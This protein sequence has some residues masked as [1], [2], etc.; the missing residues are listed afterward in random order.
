MPRGLLNPCDLRAYCPKQAAI[1][2]TKHIQLL[3][4][5]SQSQLL[6]I[7]SLAFKCYR[8]IYELVQTLCVGNILET[9]CKLQ[10]GTIIDTKGFFQTLCSDSLYALSVVSEDLYY[11]GEV[12]LLLRIVIR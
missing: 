4:A 2:R 11:I 1:M 10:V 12:V 6:R 9:F 5:V 3:I 8:C 7:V